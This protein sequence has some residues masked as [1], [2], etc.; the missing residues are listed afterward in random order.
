MDQVEEK[1]INTIGYDLWLLLSVDQ[2]FLPMTSVRKSERDSTVKKSELLAKTLEERRKAKELRKKKKISPQESSSQL[3][4]ETEEPFDIN[5]DLEW[6]SSADFEESYEDEVSLANQRK[7]TST[8]YNVIDDAIGVNDQIW[9]PR[10]PSEEPTDRNLSI[11][12]LPHGYSVESL[13]EL[14]ENEVFE[15]S[16]SPFSAMEQQEYSKRLREVKVARENVRSSIVAFPTASVAGLD[17]T[18]LVS[19]LK[20][21]FD[22]LHVFYDK[23]SNLK[24]DLDDDQEVDNERLSSLGNMSKKLTEEVLAHEKLINAEF[25]S[26]QDTQVAAEKAEKELEKAA[27][28]AEKD[29]LN[30]L[31]KAEKKSKIEVRL[32]SI[33]SNVNELKLKVS[34]LKPFDNLSDIEVKQAFNSNCEWKKEFV[35]IKDSKIKFDEDVV[36]VDLEQS[37]IDDLKSSFEELSESISKIQTD[38]EEADKSRALYLFHKPVKELSVYPAPFGGKANENV[39]KFK[40]K[41]IEAME[42]NQIAE[43]DKVEV[44]RKHLKGFPK[45]SVSDDVN[46][47]TVTEAFAILI[48]AFGNP[49]ATWESILKEFSTKCSNPSGW[50]LKGSYVRRQLVFKTTDFLKKALQYSTDFPEL[51]TEILSKRTILSVYEVLPNELILEINK[52]LKGIKLEEGERVIKKLRDFMEQE[53]EDSIRDCEL[54][55][56]YQN[57][58]SINTANSAK[59]RCQTA[60]GNRPKQQQQPKKNH[61]DCKNKGCNTDWGGLG[62]IRLYELATIEERRHFLKEQKLCFHCGRSFHGIRRPKNTNDAKAKCNWSNELEP[63]RCQPRQ[64]K[65]FSSAATCSFHS[66]EPN[67]SDELKAWMESLN[68]KTTL[69][70]IYSLPCKSMSGPNNTSVSKADRLKLQNGQKAIDFSDEELTTFFVNDLKADKEKNLDVKSVPNGDV[71]FMFT[72]IMGKSKDVQVFFDNG[73]NCAILRDTIPQTQFK[74]TL[75]KTG[76]IEIDVATGIKVQA[77][78]EWGVMLPLEDGS[79]QAVRC[80]SINKVTSDMPI[81]RLRGL[82]DKIKEENKDHPDYVKFKDLQIPS[83]LGGEIDA[84]IGIKY[85]NVYPELLFTLPNGLQIFKSK[86]KTAKKTEVLCIGGPLGAVDQIVANVGVR[87]TVRYLIHKISCYSNYKPRLDYFPTHVKVDSYF[88]KDIPE[89]EEIFDRE[90]NNCFHKINSLNSQNTTEENIDEQKVVEC[91]NCGDYFKINSIQN[92]LK[93]FSKHQEIGLDA[94]YR[95]IR[96]R[97]CVD[98][99]RGIGQ[100]LLSMKQQAEQELI[101]ESVHIDKTIKRAVAKLPFLCDP[102]E[103]LVDNSKVAEKRL[104]NVVRKY[105]DDEDTKD[106]LI[107]SIN[108][109]IDKGHVKFV[110]DLSDEI[111]DD[112]LNSKSSY[113]IPSDIAFKEESISTPARWVFDAGSKTSTGYSLN[114]I[115]AKGTINLT[116]LINMILSWHMGESGVLVTFRIL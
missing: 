18:S 95:C 78:G 6:D 67:V 112:V 23:V 68:L 30:E 34:G 22:C 102:T 93:N 21:I 79:H 86:F 33:L 104:D 59:S 8:G 40:Q 100:E 29:R 20:S 69:N 3:N 50:Q 89:L 62:C 42:S 109:L 58:P 44:L 12:D 7:N 26:I 115:L 25:K 13:V 43:K 90:E 76:P 96:C 63:V 91:I 73:C 54:F 46:V 71:S 47:K 10:N 57:N 4:A 106:R 113:T 108:K 101:R 116:L 41:M 114:D 48:K 14:I 110:D 81:M 17:S 103:K 65:C 83:I 27:E 80:L 87:T 77:T 105:K 11:F 39:Y 82:M 51:S 15:D 94:S 16:S 98:C 49:S 52:S 19:R 85:A 32:A 97:D 55:S 70:T 24:V 88:D 31:A 66:D 111:K 56:A 36:G 37:K 5:E 35:K 1:P 107:K 72:T 74:S 92:E 2:H 53:I 60:G 45:E 64:G 84:L 99:K 9:P 38:L 28:R 75:L 61:H